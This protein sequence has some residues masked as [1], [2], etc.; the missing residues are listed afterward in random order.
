MSQSDSCT[1]NPHI[2]VEFMNSYKKI[3]DK[4]FD[5]TAIDKWVMNNAFLTDRFK[6]TYKRI[7]DNAAKEDPILGLDFDPIFNAQYYPDK[8]FKILRYDRSSGYVKLC[9]IDR[10][11]FIVTVK[12]VFQNN[13]WLIDGAGIINIPK[14]KQR[15]V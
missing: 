14:N 12:V 9:G 15:K 7:L 8:G 4:N 11:D 2:A 6:I 3:C 5:Q 1:F 10:T 13:K